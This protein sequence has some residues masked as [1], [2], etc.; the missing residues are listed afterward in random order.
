MTK[1]KVLIVTLLSSVSVMAIGKSYD[2][3][4]MYAGSGMV[5]IDRHRHGTAPVVLGTGSEIN[6]WSSLELEGGYAGSIYNI[7]AAGKFDLDVN[8]NF[9]LF[10]RLGM[11][12]NV[13]DG[14][15]GSSYQAAPAVSFGA[16]LSNDADMVFFRAQYNGYLNSG[17]NVQGLFASIGFKF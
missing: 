12:L 15:S 4:Y 16:E 17:A 7:M 5:T 1:V 6:E 11:S 13:E 9:T 8:Q 3:I 14:L 10:S 2:K